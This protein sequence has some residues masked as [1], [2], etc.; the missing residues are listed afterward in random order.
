MQVLRPTASPPSR[1]LSTEAGR[2]EL[3]PSSTGHDSLKEEKKSLM[4]P[5]LSYSNRSRGDRPHR[6]IKG[7]P[8]GSFNL[9]LRPL[10]TEAMFSLD[11]KKN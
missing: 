7:A 9:E 11:C 10:M 8:F 6:P 1:D 4:L 2:G 3:G 5:G